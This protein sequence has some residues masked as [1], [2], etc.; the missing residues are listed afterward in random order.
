MEYFL[1]GYFFTKTIIA[2]G[3]IFYFYFLPCFSVICCI[4]FKCSR[5]VVACLLMFCTIK[6]QQ[7][8][9]PSTFC[10]RPCRS[11][12]TSAQSGAPAVWV[13]AQS[14]QWNF[15]SSFSIILCYLFWYNVSLIWL[16]SIFH[17][18]TT[19]RNFLRKKDWEVCALVSSLSVE[20]LFLHLVDTMVE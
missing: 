13:T 7:F 3:W 19:S 14:S 17:K 11:P 12:R 18:S 6:T 5:T 2:L 10:L 8:N 4:F 16:T 20:T 1:Y 15:T 9:F